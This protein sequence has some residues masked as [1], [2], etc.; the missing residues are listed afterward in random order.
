MPPVSASMRLASSNPDSGTAVGPGR[1]TCDTPGASQWLRTRWQGRV[2]PLAPVTT[3]T[4]ALVS[5]AQRCRINNN[6]RTSRPLGRR[7][8]GAQTNYRNVTVAGGVT[9]ASTAADDRDCAE[10]LGWRSGWGK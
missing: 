8:A 2:A 4:G 1:S 9:A 7:N 10:Q 3:R 6:V 5:P